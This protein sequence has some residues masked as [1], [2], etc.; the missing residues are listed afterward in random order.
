VRSSWAVKGNLLTYM[1]LRVV[2]DLDADDHET[3]DPCWDVTKLQNDN[4]PFGWLT[5][6]LTNATQQFC[7]NCDSYNI[8]EFVLIL[9][10]AVRK[11][12]LYILH[13]NTTVCE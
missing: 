8:A 5:R 11:R 7:S 1:Y 6:Q 3:D 4:K 10:G 9:G 13:M 12:Q 2:E